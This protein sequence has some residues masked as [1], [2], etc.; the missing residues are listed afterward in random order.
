MTSLSGTTRAATPIP[1][2]DPGNGSAAHRRQVLVTGAAGFLGVNV[3]AELR[4]RH[5]AVVAVDDGSAGTWHRLARFADDP[6][7]RCHRVDICNR[8]ELKRIWPANGIWGVLHLAAR[9]FIPDCQANPAATWHTNVQG[10]ANVLSLT[11]Q[12]SASRFL[13]ASTGDVYPVT[14]APCREEDATAPHSVYG[15]TKQHAEAEVGRTAAEP[16]TTGY[17]IARFFNLYGPSPTV[18][19]L[20]PA[21]ARQALSGDNLRLGNLDSTRDYVHVADAATAMADL[22]TSTA[23][24]VINIG[25]GTGVTGHHIVATV[26]R[27]LNRRLEVTH[28]PARARPIDRPT[29]VACTKRLRRWLP[30]WHPTPLYEGL[31]MTLAVWHE[32]DSRSAAGSVNR[33]SALGRLPKPR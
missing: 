9:H 19:H 4:R 14:D 31:A 25:T 28:D 26:G 27:L 3:I 32:M 18:E 33:P 5:L 17:L 6:H 11:A 7:V 30:W 29:L 16:G 20:I 21:V 10:T 13:L 2:Q 24:G 22:L 8:D 12:R 23:T 15:R 1:D